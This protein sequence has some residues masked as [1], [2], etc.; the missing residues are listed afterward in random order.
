MKPYQLIIF[1]T[2]LTSLE[3]CFQLNARAGEKPENI[4]VDTCLYIL[5]RNHLRECSKACVWFCYMF[6]LPGSYIGE[7]PSKCIEWYHWYIVKHTGEKLFTQ[8][9]SIQEKSLSNTSILS[10]VYSY[11]YWR[12]AVH[13]IKPSLLDQSYWR[14][15]IQMRS[16]WLCT[17]NYLEIY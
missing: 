9:L 2:D 17:I 16:L 14:K 8:Y 6:I 10:L 4:A 7:K 13:T 12:K 11:T 3:Q 1:V 5:K 15:A